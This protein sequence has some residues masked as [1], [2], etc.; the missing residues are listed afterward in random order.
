MYH[1]E[2]RWERETRDYSLWLDGE[3]VGYS[4]THA[5]GMVVL[6]QLVFELISGEYF[7]EAV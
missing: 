2:V 4:R 6:N 7:R 3:L 1:K 5:E